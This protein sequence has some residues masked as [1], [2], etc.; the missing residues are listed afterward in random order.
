MSFSI[1]LS[2]HVNEQTYIP[3]YLW[4][5]ALERFGEILID[6]VHWNLLVIHSDAKVNNSINLTYEMSVTF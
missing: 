6:A 3:A 4:Q 5:R 2:V 1:K